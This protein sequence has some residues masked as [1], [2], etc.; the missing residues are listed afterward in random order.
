M[1]RFVTAALIVTA[2]VIMTAGIAAAQ[3]MGPGGTGYEGRGGYGAPGGEGW[4]CPYCGT[5]HGDARRGPGSGRG[6]GMMGPGYDYGR[7]SGMMG[8]GSGMMHRRGGEGYGSRGW[9]GRQGYAPG[10]GP[11]YGYRSSEEPLGKEEARGIVER[12]LDT[13]R[14]PNLKV[15]E[16]E[17]KD[18]VFEAEIVTRKGEELVDRVQIDRRTGWM[19][20]VYDR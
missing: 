13:S 1:K 4:F 10:R 2:A 5:W 11:G 16:V 20:S 18:E 12:Y 8:R 3:T 19:R 7:G 6:S 15:G 17:E 14:N 9:Q